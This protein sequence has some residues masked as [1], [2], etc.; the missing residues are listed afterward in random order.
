[1][2]SFIRFFT[3]NTTV[4]SRKISRYMSLIA[5]NFVAIKN[6]TSK[7][8]HNMH[9]VFSQKTD[10]QINTEIYSTEKA[11]CMLTVQEHI[12]QETYQ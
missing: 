12:S 8:Y 5:S 6:L 3:V 2:F 4:W 7:W 9:N 1:M 10:R 11:T